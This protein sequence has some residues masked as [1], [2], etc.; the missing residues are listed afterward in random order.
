[1]DGIH[2]SSVVQTQEQLFHKAQR[3]V[4]QSAP[5]FFKEN[6]MIPKNLKVG[7]TFVDGKQTY[8]VTKVL[9]PPYAYESVVVE[10]P[11]PIKVEEP[12]VEEVD[13]TYTKTEINR[14]PNV[15]LEELCKELDLEVGTGAEMKRA[16]IGKLGL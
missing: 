13:K 15:K 3:G 9:E 7:D 1:M 16:I 10:K 8:K 11:E 14:M 5:L 2:S 12:K 6:T 4:E